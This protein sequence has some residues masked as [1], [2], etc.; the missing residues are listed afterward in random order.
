MSELLTPLLASTLVGNLPIPAGAGARG[1]A[2]DP[3]RLT[4]LSYRASELTLSG[5]DSLKKVMIE[6]ADARLVNTSGVFENLWASFV[7]EA[8]LRIRN[9]PTLRR[10]LK[11]MAKLQRTMLSI[12]WLCIMQ[13]RA[14]LKALEKPGQ[15]IGVLLH[16]GACT[17]EPSKAGV[18]IGGNMEVKIERVK[19]GGNNNNNNNNNNDKDEQKKRQLEREAQNKKREFENQNWNIAGRALRNMFSRDI[20]RLVEA[21]LEQIM[22][23]MVQDSL[24][25]AKAVQSR[26]L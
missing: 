15:A 17:L 22:L 14:L 13:H 7:V 19:E 25:E 21:Q 9:G 20:K 6:G 12:E 4:R 18:Q 5:L 1:Y 2:E 23:K 8:E 24:A 16:P 11:V 3:L 26:Y 10:K